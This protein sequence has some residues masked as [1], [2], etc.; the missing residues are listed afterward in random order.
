MLPTTG[1]LTGRLY[2]KPHDQPDRLSSPLC[3]HPGLQRRA[4]WDPTDPVPHVPG[5]CNIYVPPNSIQYLDRHHAVGKAAEHWFCV[6]WTGPALWV[7]RGS[8]L[9]RAFSGLCSRM[10][11]WLLSLRGYHGRFDCCQLLQ[12]AEGQATRALHISQAAYRD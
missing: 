3:L 10:A 7:L 2:R 9:W 12:V 6:S 4:N 5:R 1:R 8:C 11:L